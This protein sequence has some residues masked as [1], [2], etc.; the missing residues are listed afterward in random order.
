MVAVYFVS[1]SVD[2]VDSDVAA[3]VVAVNI[4]TKTNLKKYN[5]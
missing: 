4:Q 3:E 1:P 2:Q 5:K